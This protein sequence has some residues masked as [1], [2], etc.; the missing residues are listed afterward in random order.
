[1]DSYGKRTPFTREAFS[2]FV[3][4]YTGGLSIEEI[5]SKYDGNIDEIKRGRI[6]DERWTS[7]SRN[8]ISAKNDTLDIGLMSGLAANASFDGKEPLDIAKE[9]A[10]ELKSIQSELNKII[11]LLS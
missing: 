3:K 10:E 4:A 2:G 9:A 7:F 5:R 11:D 1:M 6:K 8:E